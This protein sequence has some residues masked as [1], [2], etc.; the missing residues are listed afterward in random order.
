ML[1]QTITLSI[2]LVGT[3]LSANFLNLQLNK[4]QIGGFWFRG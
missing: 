1:V 4:Y 3:Q 2:L